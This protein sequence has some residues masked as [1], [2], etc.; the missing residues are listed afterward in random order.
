M[1]KIPFEMNGVLLAAFGFT[2][3]PP[4][5][6]LSGHLPNCLEQRILIHTLRQYVQAA[7]ICRFGTDKVEGYF[8]FST[9]SG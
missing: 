1:I 5:S 4:D 7:L 8:L 6:L 9:T 2:K 3:K